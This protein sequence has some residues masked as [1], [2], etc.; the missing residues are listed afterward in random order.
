MTQVGCSSL[1]LLATVRRQADN[2]TK[3]EDD[4]ED[5]DLEEVV[6]QKL[7]DKVTSKHIEGLRDPIAKTIRTK[8]SDLRHDVMP[9]F[10]VVK[11]AAQKF[12]DTLDE[13]KAAVEASGSNTIELQEDITKLRTTL[14][15]GLM[16]LPTGWGKSMPG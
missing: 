14:M 2:N 5:W 12:S 16:W 8:I 9:Q 4:D 11:G 1:Q 15:E 6:E 13:T 7:D 10:N 3:D